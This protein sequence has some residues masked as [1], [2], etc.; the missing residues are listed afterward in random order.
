MRVIKHRNWYA[1]SRLRLES[2]GIAQDLPAACGD[3]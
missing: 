1:L 3:K 2:R